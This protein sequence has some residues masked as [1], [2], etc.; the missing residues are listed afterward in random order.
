M[1]LA[2]GHRVS[3]FPVV[4]EERLVLARLAV[5][6]AVTLVE[7]AGAGVVPV[8]VDLEQLPA[9]LSGHRLGGREQCRAQT[10]S[11]Q[12]GRDV[13]GHVAFAFGA[14]CA[15]R[16]SAG[17]WAALEAAAVMPVP[18]ATLARLA[19]RA[20]SAIA[21]VSVMALCSAPAAAPLAVA[22]GLLRRGAT[23]RQLADPAAFCVRWAAASGRPATALEELL[24]LTARAEDP[25]A[26]L[27]GLGDLLALGRR[28]A[29]TAAR[30]RRRASRLGAVAPPHLLE[31]AIGPGIPRALLP[32]V[33]R[34]LAA[35]ERVEPE[36]V[37]SGKVYEARLHG[38][39][40]LGRGATPVQARIR[41]LSILSAAA[42]EPLLAHAEPPWR[43][44]AARLA[45]RRTRRTLLLVVEPAGPSGP[46]FDPLN[47]GAERVVGFPGALA[48][49]LAPGRRP[50]GRVLTGEEAVERLL[51]EVAEG[52]AVDVAASRPDANP[53]AARLATVARLV[54][55]G[56]SEGAPVALE[57]GGRA[58]V[59]GGGR[60]RRY[61]LSRFAAR[62]RVYLPDPDAPDLVLAPGERRPAAL[63]GPSVVEC[64]AS[65]LGDG[66]AAVLYADSAGGHLREVVPLAEI[67]DHLAETREVLRAADPQ[68]VLAIRLSDELEPALRRTHR[69]GAG[70]GIVVR[71]ALP[72]RLEVDVPG[73]GGPGGWGHA[74]R[75]LLAR[76]PREG[77]SRV[78]LLSLSV[79]AGGRR[80]T[81][82]L[83]L[84]AR[85]VVVRRLRAHL[86]R[87]LRT[88]QRARARRSTG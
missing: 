47:R 74:A 29:V 50:S 25:S 44:V 34:W 71:G 81:G 56:A 78:A 17:S 6:V 88:Y 42:L 33:G 55:E 36:I 27:P 4:V 24:E 37:R 40:S 9:T 26:P 48:I 70:P 31:E 86:V 76:W 1:P 20:P 65:L 84:Y 38:G 85:S 83:A 53:V 69:A 82:L 19:P 80:A 62:P 22:A 23:A 79:T 57:V 10:L 41:A 7:A 45:R 64:C 49:R 58:I 16:L 51:R 15:G 11:A 18:A 5:D 32:L 87:E 60:L 61:A 3:Q 77:L 68:A 30:G 52:G 46:P 73:Q 28:V 8:D 67:E 35:G 43:A 54:R 21:A 59:T 66:R 14:L 13:D 75:A 12:L 63:Q 72:F 2:L 39:A